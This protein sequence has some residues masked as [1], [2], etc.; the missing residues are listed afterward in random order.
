[1]PLHKYQNSGTDKFLYGVCFVDSLYGWAVGDEG[2][3]L[4]T[5]DGGKSWAEQEANVGRGLLSVHF[6]DRLNGWAVGE[7]GR[8]RHTSD[9]GENWIIQYSEVYPVVLNSV[10]FLNK[11]KGWA[12]GPSGIIYTEDGGD[13]WN[14]QT[15]SSYTT[16]KGI[17]FVNETV[18][19]ACGAN[20][21]IIRTFDAGQTWEK[22]ETG[23]TGT[24]FD[25][26]FLDL[27]TGWA[28]GRHEPKFLRTTNGGK[29]WI[30]QSHPVGGFFK[31]IK[32]I[33]KNNGWAAGLGGVA[34]S[35]DGGKNWKV[36]I[37]DSRYNLWWADFTDKNK[38]WAVG[39]GGTILKTDNGG[40]KFIVDFEANVRTGEAPL[41]TTFTDL[42]DGNHTQWFWDFGDGGTHTTQNP[43]Y[44]YQEPGSYT[45][46]L[47]ISD[48]TDSDTKYKSN[49]IVVTGGDELAADFIADTTEGI[50]PLT[51]QFTD[52]SE[53][54]PDEWDWDFGDGAT[55]KA[56]NP[57]HKYQN[58]GTY[59]VSL[60]VSKSS[61]E[62]T[63]QKTDYI[64]VNE[65]IAVDDNE[66]TGLIALYD[67][68]PNPVTDAAKIIYDLYEEAYVT[69]RIY[70]VFGKETAV[71]FEGNQAPGSYMNVWEV[72]NING[73][74]IA[75]GVYFYELKA[76]TSR[77]CI[78]EIKKMLFI[79]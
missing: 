48:G 16:A 9:G 59:T 49:Y 47:R 71:L 32:F 62:S 37:P 79:K 58:S 31:R 57:L 69:L 3:I 22:L 54:E 78:D 2:L 11:N 75:E 77:G 60:T 13:N 30:A 63:K 33:D 76:C 66:T 55:H 1:N 27:S 7:V 15:S 39:G 10:Y 12:V 46:S 74:N 72:M 65:P 43:E 68:S 19:W 34:F 42:S 14:L 40:E 35:S 44:F 24:I 29:D 4:H 61:K 51:I 26:F 70:D 41:S 18:G 23:N 73:N 56:Q 45:V 25:V 53:G 52:L 38:G 6:I 8:I 64:I 67:C 36:Q 50:K 28:V 20:G 5:K 21:T 17:Y